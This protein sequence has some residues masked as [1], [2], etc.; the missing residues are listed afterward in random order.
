V[1]I[2]PG[3]DPLREALANVL[4]TY[5]A[6]TM[7]HATDGADALLSPSGPLWPLLR[8]GGDWA[9]FSGLAHLPPQAWLEGEGL[10]YELALACIAAK[11]A[12]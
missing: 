3:F 10:T 6:P 12:S 2:D 7:D 8:M 4:F 5:A 9:Q 11:A 1:V